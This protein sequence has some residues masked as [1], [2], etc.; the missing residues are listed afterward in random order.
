[1]KIFCSV[2]ALAAMVAAT[3]A[4]AGTRLGVLGGV[5]LATFDANFGDLL[6]ERRT[7]FGIGGTVEVDVYRNLSIAVQ[8]MYIQKGEELTD[9]FSSET[10]TFKPAFLEFPV[11]L[12]A[13][14][15]EGPARPYLMVGPSVGFLLS[16]KVRFASPPLGV[17]TEVDFK[18]ISKSAE[19]SM[20]FGGGL[21]LGVG[22]VSGFVDGRYS[23]GLTNVNEGGTVMVLGTPEVVDPIDVKTRGFQI[24]AGV[25]TSLGLGMP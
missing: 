3:S 24:M 19:F 20:Q 12:K 2:L 25:T 15:I 10:I 14:L 1:M 18:D 6:D 23:V 8:P 5:N 11:L 4:E 16:H 7:T 13:Q 21:A 9:S 17:S 22:R